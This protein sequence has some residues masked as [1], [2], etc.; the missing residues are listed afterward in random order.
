[1]ARLFLAILAA[2]S[3]L[4]QSQQ[5]DLP[6]NSTWLDTGIDVKAGDLLRFEAQGSL[7][8]ADATQSAGPEGIPRSWK[9]LMRVL[10]LNDLGRG[11]LLGRV[12]DSAAA[13]PFL[14]G[15]KRESRALVAGRLFLGLNHP[16]GSN[17]EGSFNVTVTLAGNAG[18][19]AKTFSGTLPPITEKELA[20]IPRRVVDK[21]Q[22]PGDRVNF[23]ILGTE[24]QVKSALTS[25]GWVTVDRSVRDSILRGALGSLSKQAYL[26]M[27]MSELMVFGRAQDYGWAMSDPIKT[28]M[29]RHHFRIWKA[30][31]Q[32]GDLTLWVGAGTH[33]IGFDRDQRTGGVTHKIDPET[34]KEREFI[35]E[36]LRQSGQVVK[37]D[38]VT[39]AD[40]VTKAKTAHGQ[41]FFSDGRIM[42]VY[43]TPQSNNAATAFS[44]YFC[45]VLKQN[46]PD[47][48]DLGA[49]D[50]WLQTPGK[51]DLKLSAI[52]NQYR[53]L[54]VPGIMNTCVSDNPA[55]AVGRK[56]LAEKYG[57]TAE[58]LSVPNNS[59]ESNAREIAGF[60][61]DKMKNDTRK[62]IV[63]GYSKGTPDLQTALALSP[64][65]KDSIA[66]FIS[67]AGAS[68]GSPI[69]DSLPMQLD[70]WMGKVRD[71]G[72]CKGDL[73]EGFK[74]LKKDTRQRFLSAYPHPAVPTYSLASITSRERVPKTAAQTYMMLSA[75]DPQN[76][77]QL[78]RMDQVIPE[79]KFLG[80]VWSDHLNVA[81]NMQAKF[82]RAALLESLLRF[83]LDDLARA[84]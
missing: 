45:S 17:P 54:V 47:G 27:P 68:G 43:L 70:A 73:A 11:A 83:V 74:S 10:P 15:A 72:G 20:Q 53:L 78:L 57:L 12:G 48:E 32:V 42:V 33:D 7:K 56:V 63:I 28:V 26:T 49:C 21:D 81:L 34:D 58:L 22:N 16:A 6:G 55:F 5:I 64:A 35:G 9:D 50:Q 76:D 52:G 23:L 66:A 30:P 29:A 14:I 65:L 8:Y 3:L 60:I 51:S 75:W 18:D 59:S 79:S 61:A 19:A 31:F 4:G 40:T 36:S 82:P 71:K 24:E 80:A 84:R 41:E 67:V 62:F 69:A 25:V 44:D 2:A 1:M 38:Y 39:P 37:I 77:G 13:R 46:N